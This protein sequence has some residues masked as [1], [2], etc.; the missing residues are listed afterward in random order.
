MLYKI[1]INLNKTIDKKNVVVKNSSKEKQFN[2]CLEWK[3]KKVAWRFLIVI[4]FGRFC[5]E[6]KKKK[7]KVNKCLNLIRQKQT[8]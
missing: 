2:L 8:F 7:E 1:I 5:C 6:N 4:L 3:W